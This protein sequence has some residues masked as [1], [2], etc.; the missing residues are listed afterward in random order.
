MERPHGATCGTCRWWKKRQPSGHASW[1]IDDDIAVGRCVFSAEVRNRNF[2][3]H[4]SGYRVPDEP[5]DCDG[6]PIYPRDGMIV[7]SSNIGIDETY[8]KAN[9]YCPYFEPHGGCHCGNC[10]HL[11]LARPT[12]EYAKFCHVGRRTIVLETHESCSLW[13][14][15]GQSV[16]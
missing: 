2:S 5:Y 6:T 8:M 10:E 4:T 15:N 13:K 14:W 7:I 3:V 16:K 12:R 1:F 11:H 9:G